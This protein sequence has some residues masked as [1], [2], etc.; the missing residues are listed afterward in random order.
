MDKEIKFNYEDL[1]TDYQN[2]IENKLRGFRQPF[3]MLDLWVPDEDHQKSIL[4]LIESVQISG[5]ETF[6]ISLNKQILANI[7]L[8]AL[9]KTLSSFVNLEIV[10]SDNGKEI[11]I[12]GN[13]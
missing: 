2:N 6:T 11:R 10:S 12:L 5:N 1:L 8:H 9:E 3:D 13:I 4:N 7:D